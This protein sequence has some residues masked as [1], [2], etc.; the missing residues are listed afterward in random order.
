LRLVACPAVRTHGAVR[1]CGNRKELLRADSTPDVLHHLPG[2]P[3]ARLAGF[4]DDDLDD[5]F[6]RL[7]EN[8]PD[9]LDLCVLELARKWSRE[10]NVQE[11]LM[12]RL[13]H[14]GC[15]PG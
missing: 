11:L 5:R 13:L 4:G 6:P 14:F 2:P 1:C 3:A 12:A 10:V 9:H 7:G 8:Y 15:A